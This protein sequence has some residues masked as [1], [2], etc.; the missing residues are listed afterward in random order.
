MT[1]VTDLSRHVAI[2]RDNYQRWTGR[3][4]IAPD[5]IG[6]SAVQWLDT[7]TFAVVS[8]NVCQD[9][10]FNYANRAALEL[11][12]MTWTQFTAM[13]SRLSAGVMD[14]NE[15]T[16][17]LDQVSRDGYIDNY[18]GIRIAADGRRFM[19]CDATVWNLF[20]EQNSYCGQAALIPRWE[21]CL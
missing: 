6:E 21:A 20:D 1:G 7:A 9:P 15:R 10:V 12:G 16:R 8:H 17:L 5:F 4:L 18:R 19:I 13:P 3:H 14:R 11:F 2:L